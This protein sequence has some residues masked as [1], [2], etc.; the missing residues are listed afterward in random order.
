MGN[1]PIFEKRLIMISIRYTSLSLMICL[2]AGFQPLHA[3]CDVQLSTVINPLL[4]FEQPEGEI[5]VLASNGT[6]PYNYLWSNGETTE[7][8]QNLVAGTYT[9]TV[10]DVLGCTAVV[11]AVLQQPAPLVLQIDEV[12]LD[13]INTSA[14]LEA[15]VSGGNSPYLYFWS[16]GNGN[17]TIEIGQQGLYTLT[18]TDANGCTISGAGIVTQ[19]ADVPLACFS[20]SPTL[21]CAVSSFQL[22]ALCSSQGPEFTYLWTTTNGNILSDANTLTPTVNEPGNYTLMVTNILNGCT[23]TSTVTVVEDIW[24]PVVSAGPDLEIPCGGGAV[25][26]VGSAPGGPN[27]SYLWTTQNGNFVSGINTIT[28]IVNAVGTYHLIVTNTANGCFT[29]DEMQVVAGGTGLCSIIQGRVLEDTL[30]NCQSDPGEPGIAGWIVRGEST[31]GTFFAVTEA[32]GSYQLAVKA[33]ATY[34]VSAVSTSP[35]WLDCLPISDVAVPNSNDTLQA[36]DLL[37]QKLADCP[38]LTVDIASGNLRRCFSN[39]LF[40]VSYCN[41]GTE[42]AQDAHIIVTLDPFLSLVNTNMPF[43]DLGGGVIQFEIG[44]LAVG[45]C[46]MF[47]FTTLLS[48]DAAFGQTHCTEAH[49]YPDTSCIL[50]SPQWSGASLRISSQCQADSVRFRIENVG[51]GNMP[52]ALE[53]IVVEDLVMLMSGPVQLDA[54]EFTDIS[55]PA[56]GSTWR[57]EV[58]QEPFH[59]GQ[60]APSVSVEGCTTGPTFSTGFINQFPLNDADEFIDIQCLANTGSYD[61]NDKQG[62][63]LGYGAQ[64]YIRP[65]TP[66]EYLIRFQ[67]TG[68]DTAFTVRIVDSLSAWLDPASFRPGASS[69]PYAWDLSGAGI[70]TF[71]YENILLPD[72][73][74]NE[75]ASHGFVKF[76]IQHRADAPLETLLENTAHIYFD[77]NEAI[78]TNTSI[79]RLGEQ[80]LTVG[81]WQPQQPLYSVLVS[82]N[83]FSDAAILTVKGL[84]NNQPIRLQVFDLQGKLCFEMNADGPDFQLK[85]GG[86]PN[87]VYLFKIDQMGKSVGTGKMIIQD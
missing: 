42:P 3:Q 10:T 32:D 79:H 30:A 2:L 33:G 78:V 21:T 73:N 65:G 35:L 63:P 43:T 59:P 8:I 47:H 72:S 41:N 22:D 37:F 75:P 28:P 38:L 13:C 9:C 67:N 14:T 31:L 62:F 58:A 53:Y 61:P 24:A 44:D 82:P 5:A 34:T 12:V 48:C 7:T 76:K 17:P 27:F 71:L 25:I 70:L 4:C 55:L 81:I 52:S 68:N 19:S 1:F 40:S 23:S 26:L 49:I 57:L 77:F 85:K 51:I 29:V 18:V 60:S 56:N 83:P 6:E 66:L 39:N 45:Q 87:G 69:H 74:V 11:D 86:L 20:P 36:E 54:G 84:K 80:F 64:H 50:P 46:G 15:Q 16:N